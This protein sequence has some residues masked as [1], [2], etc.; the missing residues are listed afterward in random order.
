MLS[1]WLVWYGSLLELLR[2]RLRLRLAV[3]LHDHLVCTLQLLFY[4]DED[5]VVRR[6]PDPIR[7][8]C[9]L[10]TEL[11]LLRDQV[12][13]LLRCK[14]LFS[15]RSLLRRSYLLSTLLFLVCRGRAARLLV[16]GNLLRRAVVLHLL[17][18]AFLRLGSLGAIHLHMDFDCARGLLLLLRL[19]LN[20]VLASCILLNLQL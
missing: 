2:L 14:Y 12:L 6:R 7:R 19:C 4:R 13:L 20:S 11:L 15:V 17:L 8:S 10:E 18:L 16:A 5:T 3:A 9:L 1:L